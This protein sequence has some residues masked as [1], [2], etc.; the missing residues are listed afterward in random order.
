MLLFFGQASDLN[1]QHRQFDVPC[2]YGRDIKTVKSLRV[3]E[4][5]Q[6]CLTLLRCVHDARRWHP[7]LMLPIAT[8]LDHIPFGLYGFD[9]EPKTDGNH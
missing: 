9:H 7:F 8:S 3:T 2:F 1:A 5:E 6:G 4:M